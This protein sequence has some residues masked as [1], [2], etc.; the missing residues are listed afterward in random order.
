MVQM[1]GFLGTVVIPIAGCIA[2]AGCAGSSEGV[3]EGE[4][5]TVTAPLNEASALAAAAGFTDAVDRRD[6]ECANQLV[7]DWFLE[8]ATRAD[9]IT[10][11]NWLKE[12]WGGCGSSVAN[13]HK[14]PVSKDKDGPSARDA[15]KRELHCWSYLPIDLEDAPQNPPVGY[16][17]VWTDGD[18]DKDGEAMRVRFGV[19]EEADHIKIDYLEIDR[20]TDQIPIPG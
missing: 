14:H 16:R 8:H 5:L 15:Y 11:E 10:T 6:Q 4:C 7:T 2:L 20:Q 13:L 3:I 9:T 1:R 19:I 12:G 18:I 17:I